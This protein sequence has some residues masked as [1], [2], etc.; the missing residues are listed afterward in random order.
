MKSPFREQAS[1]FD[2]V[3]TT[4]L[5]AICYLFSREEIP[6]LV[7]QKIY[8]YTLDTVT[9]G[10][11]A[12]GTSGIAVQMLGQWLADYRERKFALASD[13]LSGSE[14][15]LRQGNRIA[16][17]LNEG[18]VALIRIHLKNNLW[19]YVLA[20][21]TENGWVDCFDPRPPSRK[22]NVPEQVEVIDATK[23]LHAPNLRIKSE[24]LDTKSNQ[25]PYV[26]GSSGEREC[27]LLY[28]KNP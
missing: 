22:S 17:C 11:V 2:C 16:R 5:N 3:P 15:H 9:K 18:G 28:R 8:L 21:N 23:N 10:G 7:V 1:R 14:L 26:M 27:L 24:W 19:H 25:K 13:Y 20:L 6:P 4:F 12:R